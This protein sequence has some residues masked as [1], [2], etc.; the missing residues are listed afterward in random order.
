M[1]SHNHVRRILLVIA[2]FLIGG[3]VAASAQVVLFQ[4][5]FEGVTTPSLPSGWTD[6]GSYAETASNPYQSGVD[7]SSQVLTWSQVSSTYQSVPAID[8]SSYTSGYKFTL[9]FDL[10]STSTTA[11]GVLIG[12]GP[13]TGTGPS[14]WDISDTTAKNVGGISSSL[15]DNLSST[16][17]WQSFSFDVTSIVDNYLVTN[18]ASAFDI[19]LEQWQGQSSA[20]SYLDNL[21]L[22]ATAVPEPADYAALVGL[23]ALGW[24]IL[25]RRRAI[26]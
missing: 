24:V 20:T 12:F 25:R 16:N 4:Q 23:I 7:T 13:S 14:N 26:A 18:S 8:L 1:A 9:S 11:H 21:T 22:T 2:G 17:T 10:N 19:Y 6:S 3:A 5:T 15:T